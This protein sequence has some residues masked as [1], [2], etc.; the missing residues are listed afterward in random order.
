LLACMRSSQP[1]LCPVAFGLQHPATPL[2]RL[3]PGPQPSTLLRPRNT[4]V[5]IL[6]YPIASLCIRQQLYDACD[7]CAPGLCFA[8]AIINP[9]QKQIDQAAHLHCSCCSL[10]GCL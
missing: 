5:I 2:G 4:P 1:L 7:T 6:S 10:P 8:V 9:E 3:Q